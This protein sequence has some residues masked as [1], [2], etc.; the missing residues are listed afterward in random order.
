MSAGLTARPVAYSS[1]VGKSI[2]LHE[3]G[4]SVVIAQLVVVVP[5]GPPPGEDHK[6]FSERI[7]KT[8]ADAINNHP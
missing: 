6:T 2:T 7:A 8:V 4:S 1:T 3:N 5:S